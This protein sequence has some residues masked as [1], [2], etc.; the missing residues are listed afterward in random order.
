MGKHS[1]PRRGARQ[2]GET[3][4][5]TAAAFTRCLGSAV[6][7]VADKRLRGTYPYDNEPGNKGTVAENGRRSDAT[8]RRRSG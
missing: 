5:E 2:E 4:E 3:P 7:A 8:E 1:R 6:V